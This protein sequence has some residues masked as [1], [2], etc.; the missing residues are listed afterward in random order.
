VKPTFIAL[1]ALC[2]LFSFGLAGQEHSWIAAVDNKKVTRK[3][4]WVED[5]FRFGAAKHLH[6]V[7]DGTA[8]ELEFKG[9]G[10]AVRL[11][12]HNV[13]AYRPPNLG[14]IVVSVDGRQT[15]EFWP[16]TT[17]REIVLADGLKLGMHKVRLVHRTQDGLAGCRV[18]G[19]RVWS[20]GRGSL[21]FNI[22]GEALSHLVD[23]R[24]V[25]RKE[26]GTVRNMLVRNWMSGQCSLTALPPGKGYSLEIIAAGWNPIQVDNITVAV[27][28]PTLL[29]PIFLRRDEATKIYRF[30]FP[31]L[32]QPAIRQAGGDFRVRFLGFDTVINEVRL[33]R[34]VGPAIISRKLAFKEDVGAKYYYDREV[35][36]TLP[37]DMPPG[38]YDLSVQVTG[39][40]R[41][42]ISRSPRSVYVVGAWPKNPVFVTFGHLDTSGQYQAEYLER[43]VD[44][45]NLIAPDMVLNSNAVNPAYISG[46]MA[47][48]DMP[49]VVNFGNHQFPGHEAW[50]GD[51]VG[52][53]DFGPDLCVLNFG[54]P[55]HTDTSKPDALFASRPRARMKIINAFEANAPLDFLDRHRVSMIHDAHGIGEKVMSKGTTP[56]R[57]IGKSNSESFRVVRFKNGRVD[58]CTYNGHKTA[59]YPFSREEAS[60]LRVTF[61]MPNNGTQNRQLASVTNDYLE[62]FPNARVTFIMPHGSKRVTGGRLETSIP[63]DD[64]KY[65]VVTAR[66]D[67]PA[68][69]Q[70][71]VVVETK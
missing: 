62:P 70:S 5:Q 54:H 27:G 44:M 64:K 60:P 40:R 42:G 24:V 15:K 25:L 12:G 41:T 1:L 55:W 6:A 35:I 26:G 48:L 28:K 16:R 39:G 33:T 45:A 30:R 11:G 23:A 69:G 57:R 66:V 32:N 31:V 8:L 61:A 29:D 17:A 14:R 2:L 38:A 50:Y 9:T 7:K 34:R 43:I 65:S 68:K 3:G 36:A 59:P 53:V 56:T 19:F 22:G 46:A 49:Y 37:K 4:K 71:V 63:S 67:V 52:L 13:P 47:G 51:P 18:E 10:I 20:S 21:Q 58:T